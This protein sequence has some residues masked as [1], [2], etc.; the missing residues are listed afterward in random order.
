LSGK[1]LEPWSTKSESESSA[2]GQ[3][4]EAGYGNN[5]LIG[6]DYPQPSATLTQQCVSTHAV[7][8]LDVGG[9]SEEERKDDLFLLLRCG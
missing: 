8:R 4:N 7:Q 9:Y 6:L 2:D 5:D 3:R 1:S